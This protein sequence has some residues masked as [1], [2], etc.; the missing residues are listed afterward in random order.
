MD[1]ILCAFIQQQ[2]VLCCMAAIRT[3][4]RI[5][6]RQKCGRS[7]LVGEAVLASSHHG[8]S[9][10]CLPKLWLYGTRWKQKHTCGALSCLRLHAE[11]AVF[12]TTSTLCFLQIGRMF[13]VIIEYYFAS[14][15]A[16]FLVKTA[17]GLLIYV[18]TWE[19]PCWREFN[20]NLVY[21]M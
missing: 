7:V 8:S 13:C 14:E 21:K 2:C 17:V 12:T 20:F 4:R 9:F 1:G 3:I 5:H 11:D 16:L 19:I 15:I 6:G 18:P 10:W